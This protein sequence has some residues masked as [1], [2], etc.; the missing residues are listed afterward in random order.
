[1]ASWGLLGGLGQGMQQA[2]DNMY[3]QAKLQR[4]QEWRR[5]ESTDNRAYQ[6]TQTQKRWARE[7][8]QLKDQI[9]RDSAAATSQLEWEREKLRL[10]HQNAK[11]IARVRSAGSDKINP[12]IKTA[13]D[14]VDDQLKA[15]YKAQAEGSA[16]PVTFEKQIAALQQRRNFL[17]GGGMMAEPPPVPNPAP[18]PAPKPDPAPS[19]QP[20]PNP[21]KPVS[22]P[23]PVDSGRALDGA[24][25]FGGR[26]REQ[27]VG[28]LLNSVF[29][30]SPDTL[31]PNLQS[32]VS[33]TIQL[34]ANDQPV[35][36][37][38]AQEVYQYLA[39]VWQQKLSRQ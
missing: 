26:L 18:T 4:I 33:N 3:E 11:E 25:G 20:K 38:V 12:Y 37:A 1:M 29:G 10:Q 15:L 16:D 8:Q 24:V 14:G 7:D 17:L 27:G 32:K 13:V 19:P 22:E 31:P 21:I 36:P 23:A 39:P 35:D 34:L 6:E 30:P 28:G 5:Q 2:G 9:A